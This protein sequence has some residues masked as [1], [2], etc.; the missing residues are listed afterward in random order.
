MK[1]VRTLILLGVF[2]LCG[3]AG[4]ASTAP[5]TAPAGG[6]KNEQGLS[7]AIIANKNTYTLLPGQSGKDFR[8]RL[9]AAKYARGMALLPQ[10]PAVD[11]TFRITNTTDKPVTIE[12]GG[13]NSQMNLKLEG[14]EGPGAVTMDNNVAMTKE[15]RIG[16]PVTIAPGKSYDIKIASLAFGMRGI[17]KYAY[18]TE[19][20]D[21]RLTASYTYG[22]GEKQGTVTSGPVTLKVTKE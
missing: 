22:I 19:A 18:W 5:A 11:L 13:D 20:G 16:D 21:Y 7:A 9:D 3:A 10:P 4:S 14:P 17:S 12:V 2:A 15:F 8:E 6:P 1:A